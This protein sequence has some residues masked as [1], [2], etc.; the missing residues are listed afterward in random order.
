MIE[1]YEIKLDLRDL[2]ILR[3]NLNDNSLKEKLSLLIKHYGEPTRQAVFSFNESEIDEI[4]DCLTDLL[5][6]KGLDETDEPNA[7]GYYIESLID[8]FSVE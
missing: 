7:F 6:E 3:E 5:C 8:K 1:F 2:K 4:T